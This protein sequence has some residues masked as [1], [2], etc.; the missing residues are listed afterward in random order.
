MKRLFV[1]TAI[2]TV[3]ANALW[4][5]EEVTWDTTFAAGL[6]LSSGNSEKMAAN[7]TITTERTGNDNH[8]VRL[9]L[10]LN[11][12]ESD[13]DAG[14]SV[15]DT[16]NGKALAAYK[17]KMEQ[18]YIYSDDSIFYDD[19]ANID[20]RLIIGGGVGYFVI[21]TDSAKLGLE[22]GAAYIREA[23][24]VGSDDDSIAARIAFR[25]D[26]KISDTST[27]WLSVE[28]LPTVDDLNDYLANGEAG[29]EAAINSS[30]SLRLV[31]KDRYDST[32]TADVERND[33][34]LISSLVYKL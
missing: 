18:S 33:L 26:Q 34:S 11:Y 15:K 22:V 3:L 29:I 27:C 5:A 16:D 14:K 7:G 8:D 31:A 21:D 20:Y 12:G 1:L 17:Y 10:N 32:V 28:Y 2:V 30:L 23:M 6:N 19:M 9:E 4:A 24:S 13:N 25:H